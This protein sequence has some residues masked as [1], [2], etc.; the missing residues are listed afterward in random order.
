[1]PIEAEAPVKPEALVQVAKP[2][3][4]ESVNSSGAESDPGDEMVTRRTMTIGRFVP[5]ARPARNSKNPE[6]KTQLPF[7]LPLAAL[8]RGSVP[9]SNLL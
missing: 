8:G 6:A 3:M 1:M 2:A 7:L 4:A 9:P 5:N